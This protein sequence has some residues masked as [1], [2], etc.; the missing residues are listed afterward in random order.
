M[1]KYLVFICLLFVLFISK[2]DA[3]S[4]S[5]RANK[6]TVVVG[7]TVN[8]TVTAS[9]AAG[10]EYC[11]SFDESL[12]TLTSSNADSWKCMR[13]G[14]SM[15]GGTTATFVLKAKKSGSGTVGVNNYS[16]IDDYSNP[17]PV[18]AGSVRLTCKTQAEIEASYSTNANLRSLSVDGFEITPA[19]DTNKL[20][21]SLEVENDV[22]RVHI[23]AVRAD[24]TA[25]VSGAGDVELREGS[26]TFNIVVTAQ[27]G[28]K[29]TYVLT[30]T[31][32]ELNPIQVNVDGK[33]LIIVRK[34]EGL[35]VPNYYVTE[36]EVYTSP[37]YKS[38]DPEADEIPVFKSEI[39]GYTLIALRDEEGNVGFY[40]WD[41][42]N[43]SYRLYTE[44]S[45][46]NLFIVVEEP[47]KLLD[48]ASKT[49]EMEI[50]NKKVKVYK[51]D[52]TSDFVLIYGM[53]AET[54]EKSWYKYDIKEKTF[55][56]YD[57]SIVDSYEAKLNKYNKYGYIL[58]GITGLFVLLTL[59]FMCKN[60]KKRHLLR[61]FANG[62]IEN[63]IE[64]LEES[65]EEIEEELV[66]EEK[67][68]K[69]E[70][71]KEK[72]EAK[73]EA[74]KAKKKVKEDVEEEA[75][76]PEVVVESK[77]SEPVQEE[78]IEELVQEEKK[79]E[80]EEKK[81]TKKEKKVSKNEKIKEIRDILDNKE[82]VIEPKKEE[83]IEEIKSEDILEI[84]KEEEK[85]LSKR[86][87]RRLEKERIKKEREELKK[88][89]D[90]FLDD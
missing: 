36:K 28:N 15:G 26:N 78:K 37:N 68:S 81:D 23:S 65:N 51:L 1:K 50:N 33:Q 12:F 48:E 24:N 90:D 60:R 31:R 64:E 8:V 66:Q 20:E 16:M 41:K 3:A 62:E 58:C 6:S 47:D 17:L 53:N 87:L 88:M 10:W 30:I 74:K 14:S 86:E 18:S 34:T 67:K 45:A 13:A 73:K 82:E 76:A 21:Y 54:G 55:Q 29:K 75:V 39:S 83:K 59:I 11:L 46:S 25:S 35:E 44:L 70:L 42:S 5:V 63:K 57:N 4:L 80:K 27:K 38:E 9:G 71:R 72:K 32:K 61:Q 84:E 79:E 40:I 2:V 49:E 56:R 85:E 69:K 89:Q 7:S 77:E 22:E 52:S 19:F 43:D